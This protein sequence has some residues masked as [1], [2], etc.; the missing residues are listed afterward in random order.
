MIHSQLMSLEHF[1]LAVLTLVAA[2]KSLS[3]VKA[4]TLAK[5][6]I[7]RRWS[8]SGLMLSGLNS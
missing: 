5:S 4:R 7:F 3:S 1:D 6:T 2:M 8:R